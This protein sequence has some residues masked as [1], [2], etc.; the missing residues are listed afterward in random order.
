[1]QTDDIGLESWLAAAGTGRLAHWWASAAPAAAG[2][3]D[4]HRC[5]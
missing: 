1:M 3:M 2:R 5:L 4:H